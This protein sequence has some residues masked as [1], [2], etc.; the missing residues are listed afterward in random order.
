[1]KPVHLFQRAS[2]IIFTVLV[3]AVAFASLVAMLAFGQPNRSVA[4]TKKPTVICKTGLIVGINTG[5]SAGTD[6]S[7]DFELYVQPDL[8]FT[9]TLKLKK[10][11]GIVNVNGQGSGRGIDMIFTAGKDQLLFAHGVLERDIYNCQGISGGTLT[12]P[13]HGDTGDWTTY[14]PY[15]RVISGTR[16]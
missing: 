12:G 5:P 14:P 13:K 8:N 9:G 1:M 10:D 6:L 15:I 11:G 16:Q 4:Q 2:Y 3:S 7:G